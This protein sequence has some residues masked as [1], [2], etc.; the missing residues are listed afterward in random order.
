M[1]WIEA[2]RSSS[3]EYDSFFRLPKIFGL[4]N[5]VVYNDE[6]PSSKWSKAK[7]VYFWISLMHSI[8]VAVLEL[9]Y[10]AKSVEQNADFVFIMSL[11]PLVGHGILAIV[12]L[13]VQ[14]Y[15]H[16]EINSILISLKGIYPSTLDD[17]IT[18]DYSKKILY[19]KLFVIFY[20]VTLIFFNIV[21]FAPVLHTY[22]T[23]GVFEKTLPFFIYYWYDWRRPILYEL[24]FIEQ[25]WVSTASVVANMNIDLMLCSLILQI[26]MHFDVLS[27]RLSVLQ[28]NDHKELAKCVE[29]HSVLLDLCLRVENIFSRSMLASFLLSS[30]II[31]LTG[32]QVFAQD[33][34]NKAIPYATFL[35]LHMVDVY[36][37]CYYG[38]LMMEKSLAVSNYAYESLWYLGNRPFQKSILIILE[39]GQ[40]AQKL[41]AMKFIDINLTCFKT[42]LSTSFSYFTLLKVLNEPME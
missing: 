35:F 24:T 31:C 23:T 29:R 26:S 11:V 33:S 7:N 32:F 13:S 40:R 22:F 12:K 34:I 5:G 28:H 3:L 42:I 39:R 18:K 37:L 1:V 10:L 25:I 41:T 4:L 19:M 20:L 36:L 14:K 17:T 6:K 38:N 2:D 8:L 21:P 9:V 30:V 16:K 15:Y 27:D